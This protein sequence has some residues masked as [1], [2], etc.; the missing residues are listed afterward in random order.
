MMHVWCFGPCIKLF[1]AVC[2]MALPLARLRAA[3]SALLQVAYM[4]NNLPKVS[5]KAC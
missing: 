1:G 3:Q 2:V 5:L 4:G